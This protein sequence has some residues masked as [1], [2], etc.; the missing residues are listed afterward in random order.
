MEQRTL[1]PDAGEVALD[2]VKEEGNCRLVMELRATGSH[3]INFRIA[4]DTDKKRK[5]PIGL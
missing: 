5:S 2:Q 1:V 3:Y 4:R